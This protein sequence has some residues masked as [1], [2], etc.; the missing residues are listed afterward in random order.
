MCKYQTNHGCSTNNLAC[1]L[2]NCS[3]VIKRYE[4]ITYKDLKLLKVLSLKNQF[5]VKSDYFSKE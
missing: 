3:E 1:K 4:V 5:I 2:F